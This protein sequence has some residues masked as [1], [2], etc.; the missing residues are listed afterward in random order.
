[1][2]IYSIWGTNRTE[3]QIL[4]IPEHVV[5]NYCSIHVH[6]YKRKVG[7]H[8]AEVQILFDPLLTVLE[9]LVQTHDVEGV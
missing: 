8:H 3:P 1:M 6:V 2:G 9:L 5:L 7:T 4:R